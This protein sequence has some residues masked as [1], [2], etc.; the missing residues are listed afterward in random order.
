MLLTHPIHLLNTHIFQ[1]LML[2]ILKHVVKYMQNISGHGMDITM[3]LYGVL[4]GYTKL[5]EMYLTSTR[6]RNIIMTL[7]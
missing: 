2:A 6:Q 4:L 1:I 5:Q 3:N 7:V